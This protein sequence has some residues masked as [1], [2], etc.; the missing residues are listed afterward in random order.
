MDMLTGYGSDSGGD[1]NNSND[2][3]V[4]EKYDYSKFSSTLALKVCS[5]PE[6]VPTVSMYQSNF[7]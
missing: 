7:S 6:V 1:E 4:E 5:A 3:Q 2:E